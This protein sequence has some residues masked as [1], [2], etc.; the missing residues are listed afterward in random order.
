M[1]G[2]NL[3]PH[4]PAGLEIDRGRNATDR[5]AQS[6][7]DPSRNVLGVVSPRDEAQIAALVAWAN[8]H[9]LALV[10]VSSP[11]GP[12]R[13]GGTVPSAPAL[14]VDLSCM[15]R[16]IHVDG[17]DAI[18]LIE[19]GLTF[20]E[21]DQQ[22]R[23]HGLR[24]IKP[25]LPR[26]GKSVLAAYL[27]REP[28]IGPRDHWDSSDPLAA[29]SITFGNGETFHTGTAGIPGSLEDNLKGGN[30]QMMSPGP[31]A[32]DYTRVILGAQGTLGIVSWA[33]IYCELIPA[34]EEAFL[35]GADAFAAV[36]ELARLLALRQL[37][38]HCFMLDRAQAAAAFGETAASRTPADQL[39]A[40]LLYVSI[41]A[42][43]EL[44]DASMAWQKADLAEL[45]GAAGARAIDEKHG[46]RARDLERRLQ[47]LPEV[48]Y[49]DAP[50]GAHQEVFCLTQLD[51]VEG[52]IAAVKPGTYGS[53]GSRVRGRDLRPADHPRFRLPFGIHP[54]PRADAGRRRR[55][56][57]GEAGR[58]LGRGGWIPEP[59]LWRMVRRRL[60]PR[61]EHRAVPA[62]GED[63]VRPKRR[64]QSRQALLLKRVRATNSRR[65]VHGT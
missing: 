32:S 1:N 49:K 15:K 4:P 59:A 37:G 58:G 65:T 42:A 43:E 51:R 39:P 62:H 47:D 25:L 64:A 3:M 52:L 53:A 7:T 23:S 38:A 55:S 12:R 54:V 45:A 31:I 2:N 29:L 36:A 9:R 19:P 27:E 26:R 14:I 22:L 10:T 18:A 60:R 8:Q 57:R 61:P 13:R 40:W 41:S 5:F 11:A 50:R 17:R 30:R 20:P 28:P 48:Y 16:T 35:F 34:R 24:S 44:S 46:L 63:H 21:F 6:Q 33:S 56:A